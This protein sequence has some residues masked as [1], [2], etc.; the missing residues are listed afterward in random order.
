M[1]IRLRRIGAITG[2][3]DLA[4]SPVGAEAEEVVRDAEESLVAALQESDTAVE[5]MGDSTVD[6]PYAAPSRRWQIGVAG[7]LLAALGIIVARRRS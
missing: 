4:V 1:R 3:R 7:L 6:G 5:A 2:S